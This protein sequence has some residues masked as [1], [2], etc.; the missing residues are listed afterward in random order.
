MAICSVTV[1][2]LNAQSLVGHRRTFCVYMQD[3]C[4]CL[5]AVCELSPIHCQ[6]Q[7]EHNSSNVCM[8]SRGA[9]VMEIIDFY[10]IFQTQLL[11]DSGMTIVG[12]PFHYHILSI[13][14]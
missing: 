11:H 10:A 3:Y 1:W 9:I 2:N 4:L 7:I 12:S 14:A 6:L 13:T 8:H 5:V